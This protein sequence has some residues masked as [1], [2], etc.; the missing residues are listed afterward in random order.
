M[1]RLAPNGPAAMRREHRSCVGN[2]DYTRNVVTPENIDVLISDL[3]LVLHVYMN[4][5]AKGF[6][7]KNAKMEWIDDGKS[8]L[9][10][11]KFS[12]KR[13]KPSSKK[14]NS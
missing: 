11:I 7:F 12:I 8:E 10:C 1:G 5:K 14:K 13:K 3:F 6:K 4:W 2:I 9:T